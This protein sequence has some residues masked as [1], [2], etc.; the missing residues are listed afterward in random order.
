MANKSLPQS[1]PQLLNNRS[2]TLADLSKENHQRRQLTE[3]I[4]LLLPAELHS[5]LLGIGLQQQTLVLY[6]DTPAWATSLRY[7]TNQLI[8]QLNHEQDLR[9]IQQIRVKT[10]VTY[11]K[12]ARQQPKRTPLSP[13][14][15]LLACLAE[16][17]NDAEI[18]RS[19]KRLSRRLSKTETC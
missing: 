16:T 8:I 17:M 12:P 15:E 13:S 4:R 19:L 18:R 1:L 11:N 5:H 2:S 10:Q 6:T 7:Q 14:A 9:H 3:R